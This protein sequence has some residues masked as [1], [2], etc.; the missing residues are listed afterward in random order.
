MELAATGRAS[1]SLGGL[2]NKQE[3]VHPINNDDE[4]YAT[5]ADRYAALDAN[6][7]RKTLI[8]TGTNKSRNALN[9]AVHQAIGMGGRGFEFNLLTRRKATQAKRRVGSYYYISD[10]IQPERDRDL[11]TGSTMRQSHIS[12]SKRPSDIRDLSRSCLM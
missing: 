10:I 9:E 1:A 11:Q 4:R 6:E 3:T 7:R 12:H 8:V 5:I 2:N